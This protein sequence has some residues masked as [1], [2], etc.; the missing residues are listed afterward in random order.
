MVT[1]AQAQ[2]QPPLLE[3]SVTITDPSQ[4]LV[5]SGDRV[6]AGEAIVNRSDELGALRQREQNLLNQLDRVQLQALQ[7]PQLPATVEAFSARLERERF[8]AASARTDWETQQ[9]ILNAVSMNWSV[10]QAVI[11]HEQAKLEQLAQVAELERLDVVEVEG[12]IADAIAQ[13]QAAQTRVEF[14]VAVQQQRAAIA[15]NS[16]LDRLDAVRQE[17]AQAGT[18]SAPFS[19]EVSYVEIVGASDDRL[20]AVVH[21]RPDSQ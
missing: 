11:E 1:M 21:L 16:L 20:T 19:G 6:S 9:T 8:E 5:E 12:E 18:V 3:W 7:A 15:S 13:A 4:L 10:S 17:I 2:N 14:D